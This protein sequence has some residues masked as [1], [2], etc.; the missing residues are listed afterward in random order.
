VCVIGDITTDNRQIPCMQFDV[1]VST[2]ALDLD[3]ARINADKKIR[4]LWDPD[5][6]DQF[7]GR[8]ACGPQHAES[9]GTLKASIHIRGTA[10]PLPIH[11]HNNNFAFVAADNMNFGGSV[12]QVKF[13]AR[14]KCR[15]E[16]MMR[17][18][19]RRQSGW[20]QNSEAETAEGRDAHT[21]CN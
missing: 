12:T 2:N 13:P 19:P 7:I 21:F 9:T 11:A 1:F 16:G 18:I 15:L 5:G 14:R 6:D 3:I 20:A 17:K 4:D 10:A 8:A